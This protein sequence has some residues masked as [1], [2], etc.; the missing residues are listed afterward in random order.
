MAVIDE[1]GVRR[2]LKIM[3]GSDKLVEDYIAAN[4]FRV[5]IVKIQALVKPQVEK[6]VDFGDPGETADDDP[7]FTVFLK[8]PSCYMT[9]LPSHEL[10]S[11]SQQILVDKF[12]MPTYRALGRY[13]AVDYNLISVT[14]CPQ[15]LYASPDK[16]D[17]ITRDPAARTRA[18]PARLHQG[19]LAAILAAADDRA[20][21]L[22]ARNLD[23]M[24]DLLPRT[25]SPEA[26][27][28]SYELAF[29]RAQIEFSRNVPFSAFKM[30]GYT[31]KK[32]VIRRTYEMD[33]TEDL[34]QALKL[35]LLCFERSNAPGYQYEGMVLYQVI[36]LG[37]RT[38]QV[39]LAGSYLGVLDRS[40]TRLEGSKED[41]QVASAFLR[42]YNAAREI[43]SDRENP[44]LWTLRAS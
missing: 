37:I 23:V 10:K 3:L 27:L 41:P 21:W 25:R 6:V 42:W 5:D 4:G 34:A 9:R 44:D 18:I 1:N 43:W 32:A 12:G 35:Y 2:R 19:E 30:A 28:A 13:K 31:L 7:V 36:A 40:K 33:E 24:K 15:C 39:D 29:Q 14:I 11:K 16:K 8:C 38:G 20:T 17:F 22:A 26:G